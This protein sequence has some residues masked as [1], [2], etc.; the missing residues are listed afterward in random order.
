MRRNPSNLRGA[1]LRRVTTLG[2]VSLASLGLAGIPA[3]AMASPANPGSY[4]T[5]APNAQCG[6]SA[7]S[8]SFN[9]RNLVFGPNSKAFG[10]GGGADGVQT[11]LNN[12][13]VCGQR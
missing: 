9:A 13:A 7:A 3:A 8:G 11:G 6:T 1:R 2:A 5:A 10:Q 4:G 12:S